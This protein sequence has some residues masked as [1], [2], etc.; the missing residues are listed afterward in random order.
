[1]T[2]PD[3]LN[4]PDQLP[5]KSFIPENWGLYVFM[6]L[7]AVALVSPTLLAP[8]VG[9]YWAAVIAVAVAAFWFTT[10]PT[11]CFSGGYFCS[12]VALAILGST[13]AILLAAALR[14]QAGS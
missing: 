8:I 11:T 9:I 12:I 2:V 5:S 14:L 7:A 1:M 13:L 4:P 3:K 10:M 6:V